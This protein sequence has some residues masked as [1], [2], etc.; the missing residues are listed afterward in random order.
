M[1]RLIL[2]V[3]TPAVL[4]AAATGS[5][6]SAATARCEQS[7]ESTSQ[8]RSSGGQ[9]QLNDRAFA[10]FVLTHEVPP[11][12]YQGFIIVGRGSTNWRGNETGSSG[13]EIISR[14]TKQIRGSVNLTRSE[15][16]PRAEYDL[17][18]DSAIVRVAGTSF[19]LANGNVVLL[20]RVDAV[21]G[22][23]TATVVGCIELEP[24]RTL[25]ERLMRI[26]DVQ[27]FVGPLAS[28]ERPNEEL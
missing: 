1:A 4:F 2:C 25:V 24:T 13:R 27:T 16:G 19:S 10:L 3:T 28:R 15:S 17:G 12:R 18:P 23:P 21:G 22:P 8:S 6:Q 26:P 11:G 5:A 9:R 7:A 20:D 14:R